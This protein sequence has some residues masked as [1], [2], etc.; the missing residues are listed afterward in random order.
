[1]R[2]NEDKVHTKDLCWSVGMVYGPKGP[3]EVSTTGT[4]VD[5][6]LHDYKAHY[7]L[8][9]WDSGL[10]VWVRNEKNWKLLG[11]M[12]TDLAGD[13]DTRKSTSGIIVFFLGNNLISWLSQKQKVVA[14]STCEVAYIEA[15]SDACHGIWLA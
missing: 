5:G 2:M 3:P 6:V 15:A 13:V 10:W 9:G 8:C 11:Y 14:L 12:D 4:G 7:E 1:V